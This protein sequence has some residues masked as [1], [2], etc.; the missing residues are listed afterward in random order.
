M[1]K[2]RRSPFG[3]R[4]D[5]NTLFAYY[6]GSESYFAARLP[7]DLR[8]NGI[9]RSVAE[10]VGL[11]GSQR[12][13][14]NRLARSRSRAGNR[15]ALTQRSAHLPAL[16]APQSSHTPCRQARPHAPS[17]KRRP[18]ILLERTVRPRNSVFIFGKLIVVLGQAARHFWPCTQNR[19]HLS[20]SRTQE[21]WPHHPTFPPMLKMEDGPWT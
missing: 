21:T 13:I 15:I 7:I 11:A 12:P 5:I 9:G 1:S 2:T 20:C 8:K 4:R 14:G 6:N 3:D 16:A 18:R 10:N 19:F 17:Y